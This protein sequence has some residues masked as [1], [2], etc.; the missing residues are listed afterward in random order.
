MTVLGFNL[1]SLAVDPSRDETIFDNFGVTVVLNNNPVVP[2]PNELVDAVE[3][4]FTNAPWNPF[5]GVVNG[6]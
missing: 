2:F 1:G 6:R 3:I 4:T 5:G